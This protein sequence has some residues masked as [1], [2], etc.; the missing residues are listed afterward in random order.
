MGN[1]TMASHEHDASVVKFEGPWNIKQIDCPDQRRVFLH[2]CKGDHLVMSFFEHQWIAAYDFIRSIAG[3]NAV[4]E[5]G[6]RYG[7]AKATGAA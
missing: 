5:C 7:I 4:I 6:R 2:V 3:Q 1:Q